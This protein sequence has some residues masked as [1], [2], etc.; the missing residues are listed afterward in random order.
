[1]KYHFAVFALVA[2]AIASSTGGKDKVCKS[3]QT[4]VCK[5]NGNGGLL[6]LG[7]I[8]PGLL[9]EKCS[10]GNVYCCSTEDVKQV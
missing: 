3:D 2:T 1:M 5:G 8:A 4:V 6:S 9:G 7:N 10:G